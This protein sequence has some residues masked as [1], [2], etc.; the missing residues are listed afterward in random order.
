MIYSHFEIWSFEIFI[1]RD[2]VLNFFMFSTKKIEKQNSKSRLVTE[3]FKKLSKIFKVILL[4]A[5]ISFSLSREFRDFVLC[6]FFLTMIKVISG[7]SKFL[8]IL[9]ETT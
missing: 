2:F 9:R 3:F 5:K 6:V 1:S 4:F 7:K 8:D